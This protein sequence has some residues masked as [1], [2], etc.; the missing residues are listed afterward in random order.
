MIP[1][2]YQRFGEKVMRQLNNSGRDRTQNRMPPLLIP[3]YR[4]SR[5]FG[6]AP[7]EKQLR[8]LQNTPEFG[9]GDPPGSHPYAAGAGLGRPTHGGPLMR[10]QG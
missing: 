4:L 8:L 2:E 7:A 5:T 10:R 1:P 6:A 9:F 3:P